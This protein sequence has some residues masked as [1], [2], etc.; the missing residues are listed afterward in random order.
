M[1]LASWIIGA[2][3]TWAKE[4]YYVQN[5]LEKVRECARPL[6]KLLE[7]Q[8]AGQNDKFIKYKKL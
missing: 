7:E 2:L 5:F 4:E 3:D 1:Q 8:Q 6:L